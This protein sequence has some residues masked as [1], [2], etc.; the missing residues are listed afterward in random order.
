M[1]EVARAR[2]RAPVQSYHLTGEADGFNQQRREDRDGEGLRGAQNRR[3]DV[4]HADGE[5]VCRVEEGVVRPPGEQAV[6]RVDRGAKT[7]AG[8]Q[9]E[10]QRA[11]RRIPISG[12]RGNGEQR[13]R[14][15]GAAGDGAER[16]R[17]VR[18]LGHGNI[19]E[20]RLIQH[21]RVMGGD[22]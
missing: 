8:I 7:G 2:D 6:G 18:A 14:V 9:A 10:P 1:Q 11:G 4:G 17:V 16:G 21:A 22:R 5:I 13:G 19:V 20:R 12:H 15:N 3:T